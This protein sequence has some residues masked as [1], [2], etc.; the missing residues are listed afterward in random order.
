MYVLSFKIKKES[1]GTVRLQFC[2]ITWYKDFFSLTSLSD[3]EENLTKK[4]PDSK[5]GAMKLLENE[6]KLGLWM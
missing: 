6:K 3:L 1:K 4:K 5:N 2:F